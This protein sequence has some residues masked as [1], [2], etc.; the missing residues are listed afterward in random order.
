MLECVPVEMWHA[1]AHLQNDFGKLKR[2]ARDCTLYC[3]V[4]HLVS[5]YRQLL[6]TLCSVT[7]QGEPQGAS[8]CGTANC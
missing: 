5:Y 1:H 6:F 7:A 8:D 2:M 3:S 4:C